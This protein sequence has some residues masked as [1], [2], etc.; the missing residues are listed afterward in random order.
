MHKKDD[1][2]NCM[3]Y[4][5]MKLMS[6]TM[7]LREKEKGLG[8]QLVSKEINLYLRQDDPLQR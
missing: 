2:E 6:Y 7:K 8:M 5:G 1:M 3:N 4:G